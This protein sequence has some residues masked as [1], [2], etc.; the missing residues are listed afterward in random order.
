MDECR[1]DEGWMNVGRTND[2][3]MQGGRRMDECR[4]NE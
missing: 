2:E 4:E 3:W 1:E